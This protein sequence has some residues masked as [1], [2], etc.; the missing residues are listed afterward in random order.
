[1]VVLLDKRA[2]I[3][4][5]SKRIY[6]YILESSFVVNLDASPNLFSLENGMK[7]DLQTLKVTERT[8]NDYLTTEAPVSY[9]NG[10]TPNADKFFRQLVK[11]KKE[12]EYLRTLLGYTLTAE[13]SARAFFIWFGH[14]SNGKSKVLELL[15]KIMGSLY[16]QCD[17]SIF[18]KSARES[19]GASPELVA[20]LHKRACVY[21]EGE[22]ADNIE[23]NISGMKQI[24]GEDKI[25]ARQ[26]YGQPIGFQAY[27]KL[28]ML[29][30]FIPRIPG[31]KSVMDRCHVLFLDSVFSHDPKKGEY[32]IDPEFTNNLST[33]FLSEVFTWIAKGSCEFYKTKKLTRPESY[34][35]RTKKAILNEDAISTF[36]ERTIEMTD[37][38]KI[39]MSKGDLFKEFQEF[40]N[41]NS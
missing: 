22:T 21:S 39:F 3:E 23:M 6:S 30:N 2:Y 10:P 20:L 31:E 1:L 26:L 40:C 15:N 29:T 4:D 25:N 41:D 24:S 32:L 17:K 19:K 8:K 16:H 28:H 12:R 18:V 5:I 37:D 35:I 7:I 38:K 13:T 33:I 27:C 14:G 9:I 11:N 36:I 34:I